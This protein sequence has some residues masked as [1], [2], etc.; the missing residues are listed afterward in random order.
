MKIYLLDAKKKLLSEAQ[1]KITR[2]QKMMM[3]SRE[4]KINFRAEE[5]G[6]KME[7]DEMLVDINIFNIM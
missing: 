4:N 5:K 6:R 3:E 1:T 2:S 7:E